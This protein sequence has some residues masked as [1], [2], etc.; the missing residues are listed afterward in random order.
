MFREYK[1]LGSIL[2]FNGRTHAND[3]KNG[4]YP[5]NIKDISKA[6]ILNIL[7]LR[8]AQKLL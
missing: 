7:S 1:K 4:Y 2:S 5:P 8:T 6:L 3:K